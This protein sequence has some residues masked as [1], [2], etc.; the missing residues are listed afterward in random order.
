MVR[1]SIN[2][3][4][5]KPIQLKYLEESYIPTDEENEYNYNPFRIQKIQNYQPIYSHYFE[6]TENNYN[7]VSFYHRYFFHSLNSIVDVSTNEIIEKPVF[8]KYSPLLDPLRY[9]N[10]KYN[11]EDSKIRELPKLNSTEESV[12]KK[13]LDTNNASYIDGFFSFLSS[14]LLNTHGFKN[15]VEYYGTFLALQDKF[16]MNITDDYEYLMDSTFFNNNKNKLFE[17]SK[18]THY[19][20]MN[21]NSRGNKMRLKISDGENQKHNISIISMDCSNQT[22]QNCEIH[23]LED[24]YQKDTTTEKKDEDYSDSET[25]EYDYSSDEEVDN[26]ENSDN[27]DEDQQDNDDEWEDVDDDDEKD[28]STESSIEDSIFAFIKEFPVQMICLEKCDGTLDELF[29]NQE[30]DD[31]LAASALIQ[32]VMVLI[33]FQKAFSFTHND[34]HTN[35]IMYT[36]TDIEFLYYK[37][38]NICYKVPTYGK[39]FKI[40]DFGRSIYKFQGKLLCSDSFAPNGDGSSQYN[41]EPYYNPKKPTIEPNYSF[42]LCRLGCSIY[43]FIVDDEKD[44]NLDEL[45]KTI[46]RWCKD[47]NDKNILYKKNGEERY[48]GFSLYK[49]IARTVHKH[50]PQKQLKYPYFKQFEYKVKSNKIQKIDII[51]IDKIPVYI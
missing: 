27:N 45:Q 35:N 39:I 14:Q 1:F 11:T 36:N 40:I 43:D 20:F 15:A 29:D 32:V 21:F 50:T 22:T 48:P 13:L 8:I 4:K 31:I 47:D 5:P 17:I 18:N 51:D 23:Q 38:E 49:M 28:N 34:L 3:Y 10:G 42:D 12:Y 46:I 24:V 33:T 16:K 7:N 37:Y 26:T 9:M 30:I 41:F 19:P 44:P 25:T 2:Y 6:M